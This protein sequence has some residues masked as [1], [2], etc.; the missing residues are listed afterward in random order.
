M[1]EGAFVFKRGGLDKNADLFF[2]VKIREG[3]EGL[4][5]TLLQLRPFPE[6]GH[7]LNTGA[8]LPSF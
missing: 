1:G 8:D 6:N 4:V 2:T 7:Q 3:K 5:S